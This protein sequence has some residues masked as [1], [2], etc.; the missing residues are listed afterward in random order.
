M[1]RGKQVSLLRPT[2]VLAAALS[3]TV[4]SAMLK[5]CTHSAQ[6]I[7]DT[8]DRPFVAVTQLVDQPTL[9]AVRE[10]I[11]DELLAAGYEAGPTLRWEWRSAG[12]SPATARQ[13]ANK[14][15]GA[16]P[17][18][19]VAIANP[20]AS[21]AAAAS[22]DIPIVFSAVTDPVAAD[23]VDSIERPGE[24]VSGVS[25]RLPVP[26]QIAL[27]KEII[28]EVSSL[29]IIYD[30]NQSSTPGLTSLINQSAIEQDLAIEAVTVLLPDEA[31]TTA[32]SLVGSVN[33]IYLP[34]ESTA[35]LS[36]AVVQVGRDNQV[37]VFAGEVDAVEGGAIATLSFDYY[38]LGRQAGEMVV[39]VLEG[40]RPGDLSVEFV[41]DLRL[42]INP[43]AAEAMGV[44]LPIAV[45]ARAD[46]T[47]D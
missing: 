11:R 31:A 19:V 16:S 26:Q 13:I 6:T 41:E 14:Y 9:N 34:P 43:A 29:G 21:S 44:Q 23:L 30:V 17:D 20:N 39:S 8:D 10:G 27:I 46:N 5:G 28:P 1:G 33:A 7:G 47:I 15:A 40:R 22:Q 36:E 2:S 42:T 38:D 24:N 32:A 35:V 4:L 45:V 3:V 25:D 18:V 12:G 37:P